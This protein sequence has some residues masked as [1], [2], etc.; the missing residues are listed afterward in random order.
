MPQPATPL[1]PQYTGQSPDVADSHNL[2]IAPWTSA[3]VIENVD[4]ASRTS[5]PSVGTQPA[6]SPFPSVTTDPAIWGSLI[7]LGLHSG[8]CII[9]RVDFRRPQTRYT[10]GRGPGETGND[11]SFPDVRQLGITQ[12]AVEWDGDESSASAVTIT[13][14]SHGSTWINGDRIQHGVTRLIRNYN[15]ITIG[16]SPN[17]TQ[18]LSFMFQYYPRDPSSEGDIPQELR[19][20][21]DIQLPLGRGAYA[22]VVKALH[23]HEKQWYAIKLLSRRVMN[24]VRGRLGGGRATGV[25]IDTLKKEIDV[26]SRLRHRNIVAFKEA[27]YGERSVGIVMEFV[28]GGD[29][30]AYMTERRVLQEREAK[31]FTRQLCRALA[32]LHGNGVVHRDLKPEN[33]LLTN[34]IPREVK[35]ADFGMAKVVHSMTCLKT[36][37]G[38]PLYMAPEISDENVEQYDE[39]VDSWSLGVMVCVMLWG[40]SPFSSGSKEINWNLSQEFGTSLFG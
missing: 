20:S 6:S 14:L 29:L 2:S 11:F 7:P 39:A 23:V 10:L 22:T 27:V 31:Y 12:C 35:V 21:Y 40:R 25:S 15:I 36:Q 26:L 30:G 38:T 19:N 1:Y 28:S 32:Y 3:R 8:D 18:A 9:T 33:V 37:C 34:G 13:D 5:S 16:G 24:S 4:S 17:S